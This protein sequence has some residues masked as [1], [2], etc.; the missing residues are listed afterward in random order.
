MADHSNNN[1]DADHGADQEHAHGDDHSHGGVGKY[2]AVFGGL[3]VLTAASFGI[4]NSPLMDTPSIAWFGMMAVSCA[5]AMLVILFFMHLKWEANWK[6]VLTIPSCI[7][8]VFL[9]L[10]LVPDIGLRVRSYNPARWINAAVP[11]TSDSHDAP[12]HSHGED[13]KPAPAH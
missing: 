2:L 5:K 10:M 7:M 4:A 13:E 12:A 9:L 3:C 6:Y 8:A 11:Q 1:A